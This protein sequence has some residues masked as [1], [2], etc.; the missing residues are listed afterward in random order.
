MKKKAVSVVCVSAKGCKWMIWLVY[1]KKDSLY[2]ISS[3][4]PKHKCG[5]SFKSKRINSRWIAKNYFDRFRTQPNWKL[6]D[7]QKEIFDTYEV[8]VSQTLCMRAKRIALNG[9]V[10]DMVEHYAKLWDYKDELENTNLGSK[11]E[12]EYGVSNQ[13]GPWYFK[14]MYIC[15]DALKRG[16]LDGCRPCIS[17]DGCFLKGLQKGQLLTCVG[18]DANDQMY[19]IAWAVVQVENND[20]WSWFL[21]LLME[22]LEMIDGGKGWTLITDQQKVNNVTLAYLFINIFY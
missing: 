21:K 6:L 5:K 4:Y 1:S 11:I 15:F 19:P 2:H 7:I 12:L 17:L 20:T 8:S 22:D 14:G 3:M 18:R 9:L 16:F 10:G 13:G